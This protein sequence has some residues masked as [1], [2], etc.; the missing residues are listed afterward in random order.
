MSVFVDT[1]AL[2]AL[3]DADDERHAD[4]VSIWK[5][6]QAEEPL[7]VTSN[8]VVVETIAV[9]QRRLGMDSV[10]AFVREVLPVLDTRY[11]DG[12]A[13]AAALNALL[14]AGRRNLSLVD[15]SSFELMRREGL[16]RA[17][18]YDPHFQ[19][20]GFVAEA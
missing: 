17:Y 3:L 6:L 20:E 16:I 11:V 12:A 7:L 19:E 18:V 5:R 10:K 8:Y 9:A 4:A 14:A 1:S 15:C 13:H 2:L